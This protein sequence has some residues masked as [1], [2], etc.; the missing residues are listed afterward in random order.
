MKA[1]NDLKI[2]FLFGLNA[3]ARISVMDI[4]AFRFAKKRK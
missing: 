4:R 3:A 1:E 2:F